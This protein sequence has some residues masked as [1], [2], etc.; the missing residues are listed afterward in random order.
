MLT[1]YAPSQPNEL[2]QSM[3]ITTDSNLLFCKCGDTLVMWSGKNPQDTQRLDLSRNGF[4][5]FTFY[6][7]LTLAS[8]PRAM[9]GFCIRKIYETITPTEAEIPMTVSHVF[10]HRQ[11]RPITIYVPSSWLPVRDI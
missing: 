1:V 7:P 2:H 8:N 3:T 9:L 10:S 5:I 11:V 4:L 6:F